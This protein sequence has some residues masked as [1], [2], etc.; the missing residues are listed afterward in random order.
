MS[1]LPRNPPKNIL[2]LEAKAWAQ[3]VQLVNDSFNNNKVHFAEDGTEVYELYINK[4]RQLGSTQSR[5]V[6]LKLSTFAT[7]VA[8]YLDRNEKK[9]E[10]YLIIKIRW[11]QQKKKRALK[12]TKLGIISLI[13]SILKMAHISTNGSYPNPNSSILS[14][15]DV[16]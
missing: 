9:R 5:H 1:T 6:P 2:I 7:K 13:T 15:A 16:K 14:A 11:L 10:F 3:P 12:F 4:L 8:T